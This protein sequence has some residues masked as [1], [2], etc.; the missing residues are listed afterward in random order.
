MQ[1]LSPRDRR[2]WDRFVRA[3]NLSWLDGSAIVLSDGGQITVDPSGVDHDNLDNYEASEHVDH[4]AVTVTGSGAITGGG[5]LTASR[6]LS[7]GLGAGVKLDASDDLTTELRGTT[8]LTTGSPYSVV[9]SDE[10]VYVDAAPFTVQLPSSPANPRRRLYIKRTAPD[11]P[12]STVTIQAA[13]GDTIDNLGSIELYLD[14]DAVELHASPGGFGWNI[15]GKYVE[16]TWGHITAASA[17]TFTPGAA[18]TWVEVNSGWTSQRVFN[19][20]A[21]G[22]HHL[23]VY[24]PGIYVAN[25]N[26]SLNT[27]A[28]KSIGLTAMINGS[29]FS[30]GF[31]RTWAAAANE[32]TALSASFLLNLSASDEVSAAVTNF[33]DTTGVDVDH[34]SLVLYNLHQF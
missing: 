23:Q 31:A 34:A 10:T 17:G 33:T 9:A 21:G 19:M 20:V 4:S 8:T 15:I 2:N 29:A 30:A 7:L 12:V 14:H 27:G 22:S 24:R 16:S 5:D 28:S 13:T 1:D 6:T 25:L 26:A 18:G 11:T 32:N 3:V